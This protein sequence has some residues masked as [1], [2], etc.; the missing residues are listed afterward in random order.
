VEAAALAP[1]SVRPEHQKKGVGSALIQAGITA[2]NARGLA[3][4]VVLGHPKLYRRFG[5]S[6]AAARSLR[7]P[8][9]G[10]AFMAL[11]LRPGGL[12][13]M[14]ETVRY[15]DAFDALPAEEHA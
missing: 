8:F 6:A 1:L 15:A 13:G 12:V 5:F 14:P 11:E 4:I 3:G 9:S 10:D 7:A 2:C